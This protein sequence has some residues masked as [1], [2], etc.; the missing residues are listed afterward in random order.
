MNFSTTLNPTVEASFTLTFWE[1][2][3]KLTFHFAQIL[4]TFLIY[5]LFGLRQAILIYDRRD[6]SEPLTIGSPFRDKGHG[7]QAPPL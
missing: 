4:E 3:R 6:G 7:P 1:A 5:P 2:H